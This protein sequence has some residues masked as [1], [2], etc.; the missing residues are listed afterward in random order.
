[1][2]CWALTQA[3]SRGLSD[4]SRACGLFPMLA[5]RHRVLNGLAQHQTASW[6]AGDGMG[7][8][9][10]QYTRFLQVLHTPR[11]PRLPQAPPGSSKF[12]RTTPLPKVP[13]GSPRPPGLWPWAQP[14]ALRTRLLLPF[15]PL[16][17]PDAWPRAQPR[18]VHTEAEGA[19]ERGVFMPHPCR[20][21]RETDPAPPRQGG[22]QRHTASGTRLRSAPLPGPAPNFSNPGQPPRALHCQPEVVMGQALSPALGVSLWRAALRS[23][24][25]RGSRGELVWRAQG[26]RLEPA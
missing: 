20:E 21:E 9:S 10:A 6:C 14:W 23:E 17:P 4:A 2:P 15:S 7:P 8:R 18:P 5:N 24:L 13:P 16:S 3:S 1:M 12:P 26:L 19:L 25:G 11:F 22:T